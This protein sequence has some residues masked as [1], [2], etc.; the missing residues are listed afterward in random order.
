MVIK[1]NTNGN[2]R[3][4]D[5]VRAW[6][7]DSV[8]D[9]VYGGSKGSGKSYIG[10]SLICADALMY[11]ET[12]YFIARKKLSDLR[13]FTL[14]SIYEVLNHYGIH[15]KYFK[16]NGVDNYITFH[17]GS[18]IFLLDAKYI[19]SDP[20]YARFGSM[21]MTRGWIEEAGEFDIDCKKNLQISIGRWNNKKY[22]LVGKLLNTCNPAK[23]YLYS[24]FYKPNKEGTILPYRKF[25]QALPSDNKMLPEGY[26]EMLERT[27][28]SN[29]KQRL[30]YGNW[31][32]DDNP[33]AMFDYN[34][35]L[36]MFTNE[37]VK[38]TEE[39]YMS[40]DIAYTGSDRF[41]ITLWA[42]FVVKK[43]I[44]IDKIDDTMVSK[45]IH[46]LR[47]EY[48]IPIKNV[49]YDADGLQTFTR[50]S[51][52]HGNLV[53]AKAFNNGGTPLKV[54]GKTENFKNLKAQCYH[55]F[56]EMVKANQVYIEDQAYRKQIIEEVEQICRMPLLDDGKFALEKKDDLRKRLGRSS[57]FADS[58]AMRFMFEIKGVKKVMIKW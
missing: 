26:L 20:T 14:P 43:V 58:L 51:T 53:G 29:A 33:Y 48:G 41:V 35:V 27:L 9:I 2:E 38:P 13:K 7:D 56:A 40:C 6:V 25:I 28:D 52:K 37:F 23:N 50:N 5:C 45:K 31:E 18:K 30:L 12:F 15:E 10:C 46:E 39:R 17:N 8:S 32:F 57:D 47:L 19:P 22:G 4:K 11:P 3:Q 34:D 55:K 54:S 1:F 44:A 42:G 49:I 36:G 24:D 16:F 21:Q